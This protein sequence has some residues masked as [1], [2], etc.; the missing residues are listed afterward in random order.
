M[1]NQTFEREEKMLNIV[2]ALLVIGPFL[3]HLMGNQRVVPV[4]I[5]IGKRDP[6]H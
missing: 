6:G 2:I 3:P 4:P 5:K 1:G